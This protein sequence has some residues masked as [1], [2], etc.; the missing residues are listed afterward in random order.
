[1]QLPTDVNLSTLVLELQNVRHK[2]IVEMLDE[3]RTTQY[4]YVV[5]ED[6]SL[7]FPYITAGKY[8][9]RM[10]E[11]LNDNSFVDTGSLL[12]HQMPERVQYFKIDDNP[13]LDIPAMSIITQTVDL[14]QM[15]R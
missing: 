2:Y 10:T 6:K 8:Y 1:M 13:L 12:Q 4:T 7:E 3:R 5:N 15:F 14:E 9:V 11:D